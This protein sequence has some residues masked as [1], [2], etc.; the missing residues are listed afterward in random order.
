[1]S[2][3]AFKNLLPSSQNLRIS[4]QDGYNIGKGGR[5]VC[6][7]FKYCVIVFTWMYLAI[8]LSTL[9]TVFTEPSA[10]RNRSIGVCWIHL[11]SSYILGWHFF[12][13]KSQLNIFS[14]LT[15]EELRYT[16]VSVFCWF[17]RKA[18]ISLLYFFWI[19]AY[20]SPLHC[21]FFSHERIHLHR[22][23]LWLFLR[24]IPEVLPPAYASLVQH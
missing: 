4:L 21:H 24:F 3:H 10:Y 18:V 20:K 16:T 9:S 8:I 5:G 19:D 6:V 12:P 22:R 11:H 7:W 17:L 15:Y 13:A 2:C 23:S 1:M 14:G